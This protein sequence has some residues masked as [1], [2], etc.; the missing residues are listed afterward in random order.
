MS[1]DEPPPARTPAREGWG[2]LHEAVRELVSAT[3]SAAVLVPG[4]NSPKG[5][6]DLKTRPLN[7]VSKAHTV[8]L[9]R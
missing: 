4:E 8:S 2:W 6:T 3:R 5:L 1:W 7:Q 9:F